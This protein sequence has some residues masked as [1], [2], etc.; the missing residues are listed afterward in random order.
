MREVAML[1]SRDGAPLITI[2][3]EPAGVDFPVEYAMEVHQRFPG[4]IKTMAHTHPRD[5]TEMSEEDR[6]TLK[7]WT[8]T[9]SPYPIYMDVVCY[10]GKRGTSRKRYWY[11]IESLKQWRKGSRKKPRKMTLRQMDL[12]EER[13]HWIRTITYL[14][15][16]LR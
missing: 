11:D 15:Y 14:S 2:F 4:L 6:T 7:A 8:C 13:A 1:I 9:F 10:V 3:G 5:M 12:S 16:D